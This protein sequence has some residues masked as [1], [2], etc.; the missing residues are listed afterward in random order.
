[1]MPAIVHPY[2]LH[3]VHTCSTREASYAF[4][5]SGVVNKIIKDN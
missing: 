2:E 3:I 5:I 4:Q 1:M